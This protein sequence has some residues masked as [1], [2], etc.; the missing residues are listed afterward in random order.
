MKKEYLEVF[1]SKAKNVRD[2]TQSGS[3]LFLIASGEVRIRKA[4]SIYGKRLSIYGLLDCVD[5][6]HLRHQVPHTQSNVYLFSFLL[7]SFFSF[8]SSFPSFF[9]SL[10]Y[11]FFFSFVRYHRRNS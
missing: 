7:P 4:E 3:D 10:F 11:S 5:C 1:R 2:I 6:L 9:Y 8:L